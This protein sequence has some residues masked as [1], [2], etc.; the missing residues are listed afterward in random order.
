MEVP[1]VEAGQSSLLRVGDCSPLPFCHSYFQAGGGAGTPPTS[2]RLSKSGV[3]HP[4]GTSATTGL[5]PPTYPSPIPSPPH[6]HTTSTVCDSPTRAVW[7][8]A[9][10]EMD[11]G[12]MGNPKRQVLPKEARGPSLAQVAHVPSQ[13]A[14]HIW[15]QLAFAATWS[16]LHPLCT[17]TPFPAGRRTWGPLVAM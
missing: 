3:P 10:K 8:N 16:T 4:Q 7:K 5:H 6:T 9:R 13:Q 12:W 15:T 11:E 17:R 14:Q 1:G 2:A